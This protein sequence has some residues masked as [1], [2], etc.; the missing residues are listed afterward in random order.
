MDT[1]RLFSGNVLYRSAFTFEVQKTGGARTFVKL[2]G[3]LYSIYKGQK[4]NGRGGKAN[5]IGLETSKKPHP[6]IILSKKVKV[7]NVS[8]MRK[9]VKVH[10]WSKS[11]Q[12]F[13]HFWCCVNG[14]MVSCFRA[15]K[16]ADTAFC[17]EESLIEATSRKVQ[18]RRYNALGNTLTDASGVHK[19]GTDGRMETASD[20]SLELSSDN[21]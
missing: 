20:I 10:L 5:K 6:N 21:A 8:I 19:Q 13:E 14:D 16:T 7:C 4:C 12:S 11:I 2:K 9:K 3:Y 15:C 18:V 17:D 1:Q